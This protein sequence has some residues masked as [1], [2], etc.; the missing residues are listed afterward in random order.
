MIP[1]GH[2]CDHSHV[3]TFCASG[4]PAGCRPV[5]AYCAACDRP[6][7]LGRSDRVYRFSPTPEN[8]TALGFSGGIGL[9]IVGFEFEYANMTED[10]RTRSQGCGPGPATCFCRRRSISG[11]VSSMGPPA[12]VPINEELRDQSET[13]AAANF[14][15]G[16]KI[17]LVGP[18]RLRLDYRV[19]K[20]QG[21]PA[22]RDLSSLLRR[23]EPALLGSRL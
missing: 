5:L 23:R 7:S 22:L 13:N 10:D 19:F 17:N 11:G 18:L 12:A 16:A 2:P 14:G 21:S 1:W 4:V 8:R 6:P 9:L 3:P 15:G 20:L